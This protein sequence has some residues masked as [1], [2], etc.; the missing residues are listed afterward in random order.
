MK[1]MLLIARK[2]LGLTQRKIADAL[3]VTDQ[4]VSEWERGTRK[5]SLTPKQALEFC[6]VLDVS[7]EELAAMFEEG[8]D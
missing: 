6:R 8:K 2:K 3:G 5:P 4:S 7:I 1:T